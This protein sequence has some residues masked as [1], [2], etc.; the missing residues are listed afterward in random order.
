VVLDVRGHSPPQ[1]SVGAEDGGMNAKH[2]ALL[3]LDALAAGDTRLVEALAVG[4]LEDEPELDPHRRRRR[5]HECGVERW[6]GQFEYH[7][8]MRRAA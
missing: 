3:V 6:P 7:I 1:I 8:H 5:C 4:V 2:L